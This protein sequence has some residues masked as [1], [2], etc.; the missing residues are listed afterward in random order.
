MLDAL[1]PYLGSD[2]VSGLADFVEASFMFQDRY[3]QLQ[4]LETR[5]LSIDLYYAQHDVSLPVCQ[6]IVDYHLLALNDELWGRYCK[7]RKI[8]G[9]DPSSYRSRPKRETFKGTKKL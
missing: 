1:N 3:V 9:Y 4:Y 7:A 2:T 6:A 5:P 8:G